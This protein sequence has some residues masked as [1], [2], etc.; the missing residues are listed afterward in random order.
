[1]F[2]LAIPIAAAL[3]AASLIFAALTHGAAPPTADEAAAWRPGA[4]V[5]PYGD[6]CPGSNRYGR[7]RGKM[8][9]DDAME[10]LTAHYAEKGFKVRVINVRGRFLKAEILDND[11]V[12]DV[13]IFDRR[14]GRIRSIYR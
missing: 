7:C 8:S 3:V 11:K 10:T 2:L 12:V 4:P 5:T 1:M 14:F 9:Y 13:I 6:Y